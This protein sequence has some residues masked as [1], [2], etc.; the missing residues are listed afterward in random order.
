VLDK[1]GTLTEGRTRLAAWTGPDDVR[2]LVLALER[3][4]HHP[5][6]E[7]FRSAWS[8][9]AEAGEAEQVAHTLGG[10]LSGRVGGR[11]VV[12]GAPAYVLPQ[13]ADPRG[14]ARAL[15]ARWTPVIVA[16]DGEVVGVASFG[17]PVR[18]DAPAALAALRAGGWQL[19]L[20]SGDAVPVV[21][22]VGAELGFAPDAVRGAA[23]PEEKLRRI[24]ALAASHGTVVMV[25][26]GVNDAAAMARASVGVGVHGGA[27][28]CLATAD[29]FLSRPGLG[30][31][32]EL[33]RGAARTMGVIRRNIVISLGY[34]AVGVGLAMAGVLDPLVA[35]ILMPISS[36]TVI[37]LSWR[38]RTFAEAT[39]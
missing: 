31:L 10:G 9:V 26:D 20:L 16:V 32:V 37:L 4:S 36:A 23:T 27:E 28:A 5:V 24:E 21:A 13:A 18:P 1:T 7:G 3:H 29:V 15:D 22:R 17:D 8:G 39:S 35:A 33:M 19:E 34:N 2:P 30:P 25:G 11:V 12:A 14:L 38:S 6:A